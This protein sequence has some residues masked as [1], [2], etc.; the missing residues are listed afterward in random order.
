MFKIYNFNNSIIINLKSSHNT[1]AE[2]FPDNFNFFHN[3]KRSLNFV[4]NKSY[5]LSYIFAKTIILK[6]IHQMKLLNY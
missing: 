2:I 3:I 1:K 5:K 6:S 4:E